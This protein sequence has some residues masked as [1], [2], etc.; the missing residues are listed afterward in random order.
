MDLVYIHPGGVHTGIAFFYFDKVSFM[1]HPIAH[2]GDSDDEDED[3]ENLVS[4]EIPQKRSH[5]L[6]GGRGGGG[7]RGR[8]GEAG[9]E[10]EELSAGCGE[11]W[12]EEEG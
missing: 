2:A 11:S 5:L 10:K 4:V 8:E 1:K 7:E 3:R 9:D 12:Q 6:S